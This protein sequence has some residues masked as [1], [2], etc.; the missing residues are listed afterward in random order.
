M[1]KPPRAEMGQ[2]P[3]P[4]TTGRS[5]SEGRLA[6]KN[7]RAARHEKWEWKFG[8]HVVAGLIMT[9]YQEIATAWVESGDGRGRPGGAIGRPRW[10][11]FEERRINRLTILENLVRREG[12]D[13]AGRAAGRRVI[14]VESPLLK[15]QQEFGKKNF[16]RGRRRRSWPPAANHEGFRP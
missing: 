10:R 4:A 1:E 14:I 8:A 16:R 12:R 2:A 15:T 13:V 7:T 9:D 3:G 5:E 11:R 6:A